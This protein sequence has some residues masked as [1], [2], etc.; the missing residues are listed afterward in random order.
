LEAPKIKMLIIVLAIT[1]AAITIIRAAYNFGIRMFALYKFNSD[2]NKGY[3][4]GII[5]SSDGP[6]SI[7]VSDIPSSN[8]IAIIFVLLIITVALC[9]FFINKLKK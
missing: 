3:S 8:Y 6:T 1:A 2:S 5:G 4:I 9:L 7:F